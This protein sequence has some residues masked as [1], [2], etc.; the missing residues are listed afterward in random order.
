VWSSWSSDHIEGSLEFE[1][2]SDVFLNGRSYDSMTSAFFCAAC[3]GANV[4]LF[5]CCVDFP[6]ACIRAGSERG[7]RFASLASVDMSETVAVTML[8]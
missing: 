7:E 5:G 1:L 4:E 3:G 2:N 8:N 6:A